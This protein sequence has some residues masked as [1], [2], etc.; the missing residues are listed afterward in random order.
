[1]DAEVQSVH[2]KWPAANIFIIG[3]SMGGLVAALYYGKSQ[4]RRTAWYQAVRGVVSLDSPINGVGGSWRNLNWLARFG[5]VDPQ[6]IQFWQM[7]WGQ[8]GSIDQALLSHEGQHGE[9]NLYVPVGTYTDMIYA[10][11]DQPNGWGV[12]LANY[13]PYWQR[14][15][16]RHRARRGGGEYRLRSAP[17]P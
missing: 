17:E 9:P 1:M 5:N 13:Q 7:C 6:L 12:E 2:E 14:P 4:Y 8:R 15:G 3:H 16:S 11:A 10:L